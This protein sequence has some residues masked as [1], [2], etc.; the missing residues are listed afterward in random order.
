[1]GST[2]PIFFHSR[3]PESPAAIGIGRIV[4]GGNDGLSISSYQPK[5]KTTGGGFLGLFRLWQMFLR[6]GLPS[7]PHF[8]PLKS[9]QQLLLFPERKAQILISHF[10]F[11]RQGSLSSDQNLLLLLFSLISMATVQK[12]TFEWWWSDNFFSIPRKFP[13]SDPALIA[14]FKIDSSP[15]PCHKNRR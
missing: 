1:M 3:S 10:I 4:Y 7:P 9:G 15:V 5:N 6:H 11:R 8:P 12:R 2:R 13:V 14:H